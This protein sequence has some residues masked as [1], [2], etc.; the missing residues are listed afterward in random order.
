M[1]HR[2]TE[3]WS[4]RARTALAAYAAPLRRNVAAR[5]LRLRVDQPADEL[6]ERAVATLTNPP[7]VDRRLRDLSPPARRLLAL[8]GR[9]RQPRWKVAH[10]LTLLAALDQ[11]EGFAPVE[12]ALS[13]GL[14]FPVLPP[15]TSPVSDFVTWYGRAGTLMAEVFTPPAIAARARREPLGLPDLAATEPAPPPSALPRAAD[16][17]DWPLRLAAAWQLLDAGPARLTQSRALFK[18]DLVRLQTDEVLSA[19][20]TTDLATDLTDPGVLA[21]LWADQAGLLVEHASQLAAAPFPTD[22]DGPLPGLLADLL[23]AFWRVEAWDPLAGYVPSN[24]GLSATPTAALLT[25]LLVTEASG[26]VAPAAVAGWLWSHHPTWPAALPDSAATDRG[27]AWVAA[28]LTGIAYPLGLV[29]MADGLARPTPAG[30]HLLA[31]GPEPPAPPAFSQTLLVQPNAEILAYRQGL[32]PAL[33]AALSRFARWKSIGPACTLELTAAQTYRGLES[34]L[35]LPAILQTLT[36]HSARPV[37]PAVA[38]LLGRWA[39]KRERITVYPSAVLVEFATPAE[40]EAALA[41]GLVAV[42]LTD[43]IG[44]T[45]DGSEPDLGQLRL[46]AN[47]D[48]EARPQRCVTVEDDG[49]TL[50]VDGAAADLLL[51]AELARLAVPLPVAPAAPRRF[52]LD[53]QRLRQT[54]QAIS[55]AELDAWFRDRTG[56]PLPPA[57][58]LFLF[59]PQAP[60]PTLAR[61]WV[62]RFATAELLDGVLQWPRTRDLIAERLGPTAA[63]VDPDALS[64]LRQALGELGIPLDSPGP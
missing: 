48:Y 55:P 23:A 56:Q 45:A 15:D 53:P 5:L 21:V 46:I 19:A 1:S 34:G 30:R 50:T 60:P 47:R 24:T 54:G 6:L 2:P 44:M 27:S 16:G 31:D 43:R 7:A 58:R 36:R 39:G 49:I 41:R 62:V 63:A 4:A 35:T 17:W 40:L 11:A 3:D 28:F 59:G 14:L 22:W 10:L 32:T 61:L 20:P 26:W 64:A 12:E 57:G 29:E 25:L 18:K 13:A 8:I 52:R 38:D 51:D 33:V 42:R 37:P 9:S